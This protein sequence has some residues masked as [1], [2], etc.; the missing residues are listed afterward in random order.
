MTS[1]M[2]PTEPSDGGPEEDSAV[3]TPEVSAEQAAAIALVQQNAP[4]ARFGRFVAS[5]IPGQP[6]HHQVNRVDK[7]G[8]LLTNGWT[9]LVKGVE[10]HPGGKSR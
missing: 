9:F 2:T 6:Q 5:P 1:T 7:H 8:L 10:E 4:D 3:L